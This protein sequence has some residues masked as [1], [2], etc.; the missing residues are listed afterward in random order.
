M[1]QF[2]G[3]RRGKA[4]CGIKKVISYKVAPDTDEVIATGDQQSH[5]GHHVTIVQN[6]NGFPQVSRPTSPALIPK[7]SWLLPKRTS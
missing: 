1:T 2:D 4:I 3:Q 6:E 7:S 5:V